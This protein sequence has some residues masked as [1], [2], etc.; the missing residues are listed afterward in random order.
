M[1]E[2][3]E[4]VVVELDVPFGAAP[5]VGGFPPVAGKREGAA[6]VEDGAAVG[7]V[8]EGEGVMA[9]APWLGGDVDGDGGTEALQG[10]GGL[11]AECGMRNAE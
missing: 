6:G 1:G 11:N 8:E 2:A 10:Q 3:E 7:A 5:A 9:A 4:G